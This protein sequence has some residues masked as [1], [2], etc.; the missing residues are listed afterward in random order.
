MVS[1]VKGLDKFGEQFRMRL[2]AGNEDLRSIVGSIMSF[3]LI[4]VVMIYAY[5]KADVLVNKKDIDI[6]S[7]INEKYFDP[8]YELNFSNGFNIAAAFT[9]FDSETEDILDPTYGELV[10]MHYF[11]GVQEDG[12]YA[13]GRT[14]IT[15]TH[16]CTPEELGL[17]N[18]PK[19]SKF[20]PPDE[21]SKALVEIYQKKF[22]CVGE[23]DLFAKGDW[24]ADRANL[25]NVQ[26]IKCNN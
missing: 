14:R 8:D 23:E 13:A 7:T 1:K 15:N 4:L 16:N 26:L 5:L 3:I 18:D 20:M 10:F 17:G 12:K 9:A 11:W 2:D 24:N 25:M 21:N 22:K 19:K 6:L